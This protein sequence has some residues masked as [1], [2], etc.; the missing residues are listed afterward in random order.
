MDRPMRLDP[1]FREFVASLRAH[2]ARFLIVDG[3]AVAFH[4]IPGYTGHLDVSVAAE[5]DNADA[6][7]AVLKEFGLGGL[8]V[9]REDLMVPAR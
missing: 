4:G 1:N 2:D 9:D 8:G 3:Y 6:V 7:M 5:A